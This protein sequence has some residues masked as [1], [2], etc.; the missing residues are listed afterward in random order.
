M[1]LVAFQAGPPLLGG[2]IA[3]ALWT[4]V[5]TMTLLSYYRVIR[6]LAKIFVPPPNAA[7]AV[8]WKSAN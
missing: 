8:F 1:P 3:I 7:R 2:A 4:A 5:A 6:I